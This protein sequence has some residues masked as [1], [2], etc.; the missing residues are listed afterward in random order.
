MVSD[1]DGRLSKYIRIYADVLVITE[2]YVFSL[3]FK[4]DE[5]LEFLEDE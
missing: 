3:E 2:N 1:A 5:Y 4:F